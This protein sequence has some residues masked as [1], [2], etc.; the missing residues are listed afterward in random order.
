VNG[1]TIEQLWCKITASNDWMSQLA[2]EANYE[3]YMNS[4]HQA[5]FPLFDPNGQSSEI[6]GA[7]VLISIVLIAAKSYI[8]GG[9]VGSWKPKPKKTEQRIEPKL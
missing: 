9:F 8:D 2:C 1:N 3:G 4:P 7:I 6:L 5:Q